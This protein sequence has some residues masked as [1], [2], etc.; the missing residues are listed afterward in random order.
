MNLLAAQKC[1]DL[2]ACRPI[3][4]ETHSN[5]YEKKLVKEEKSSA[6]MLNGKS[7]THQIKREYSCISSEIAANACSVERAH[8]Y[9]GAV[10]VYVMHGYVM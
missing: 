1:I 7:P 6:L 4:F 5:K 8:C 2:S 3:S 10:C 9:N